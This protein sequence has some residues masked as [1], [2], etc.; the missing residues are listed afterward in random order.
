[1]M[2]G[3]RER[4]RYVRCAGCGALNL[5]DIPED[6]NRHYPQDYYSF[7]RPTLTA[8]RP[9]VAS[10]KRV[11]SAFMLRVPPGAADRLIRLSRAPVWMRWFA[12]LGLRTTSRICDVGCGGGSGLLGFSREG[13]TRLTGIDP[14]MPEE[15]VGEFAGITFLRRSIDELDGE[16]DAFWLGHVLEHLPDPQPALHGLAERLAPGGAIIIHVPLADSYASRYYGA[17]WV[18][19][20]APRHLMVPTAKAMALLAERAG[21]RVVRSAR[22]SWGF[23]F[24]GSEQSR[25]GIPLRSERS[26]AMNPE[27]SLFSEDD[28]ASFERRAAELDAA[29]EGDAGVF[30]LARRPWY[31]H[32]SRK[33]H[34]AHGIVPASALS[35]RA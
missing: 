3:S 16:W 10:L 9:A 17:D 20:D 8:D 34:L 15:Q 26:Y 29:G 21:L 32:S 6:L 33:A 4:F 19:L 1:M 14:Y 12:G 13:F 22:A 35:G 18:Q 24:W 23:Q 30:V 7:E 28:I 5:V 25:R 11:R 2:Y 31:S 27:A